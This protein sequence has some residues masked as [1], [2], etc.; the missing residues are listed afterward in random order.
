MGKIKPTFN[1]D[2]RLATALEL[3]RALGFPVFPCHYII[4]G[5]C[6]CPKGRET[7]EDGKPLCTSGKHPA[8]RTGFKDASTT[9]ER[10]R[11]LWRDKQY[12]IGLATGHAWPQA[13]GDH[14]YL[15]VPDVDVSDSRWVRIAQGTC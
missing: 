4:G 8:T 3:V 12:N 1:N 2:G 9:E 13:T 11:Q 6:S 14:R 5:R 15:A 10:I 7:D